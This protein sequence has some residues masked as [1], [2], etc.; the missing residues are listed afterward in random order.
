LVRI[1]ELH[2]QFGFP[3]ELLSPED[4]RREVNMPSYG[5]L[6]TGRNGYQHPF[7]LSRGYRQALLRAGVRLHEGTK[8]QGFEHDTRAVRL[9]TERGT[10]TAR[11]A[12]FATG[13]Y[14]TLL[15]MAT[16]VVEPVY[17]YVVATEPLN[18]EQWAAVGWGGRHRL[19]LDAGLSYYYMQMRPDRKF[20]FGG[21][22]RP[23][24]ASGRFPDHDDISQYQ[25]VHREMTRRFP[26]L[27]SAEI[28][29]AWGGPLDL[30]ETGMPIIMRIADSVYLN[31]GYNGR[32]VLMTSLSGKIL[33]GNILGREHADL[34]YE[35]FSRLLL[36][37]DAPRVALGTP[38]AAASK[39]REAAPRGLFSRWRR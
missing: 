28:I 27:A 31:V 18:D 33:A 20:L 22:P 17:T 15:D 25:R 5:A 36:Q 13:A 24:S 32:G 3:S 37:F 21:G 35:K 11:T 39:T 2:R 9:R 23:V 1:H 12:V 29:S 38:A 30:T 10:I 4:A 6:T 19:I 34:D 14:T 16:K 7:K 26:A 8:A